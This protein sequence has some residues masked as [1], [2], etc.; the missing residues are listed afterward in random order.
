MRREAPQPEAGWDLEA[1]LEWE[2]GA[3]PPPPPPTRVCLR[4][5]I[6]DQCAVGQ[7]FA[8]QDELSECVPDKK[9]ESEIGRWMFLAQVANKGGKS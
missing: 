1:E 6:N 5:G 7:L 3:V 9:S 4:G 8:Q 2:G